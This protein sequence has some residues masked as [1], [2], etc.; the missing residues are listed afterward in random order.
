ME[1]L[2]VRIGCDLNG[3]S[4]Y[5]VRPNGAI[6]ECGDSYSRTAAIQEGWEAAVWHERRAATASAAGL[7]PLMHVN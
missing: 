3:W 5:V 4:W 7:N 2:S 6:V 1:A